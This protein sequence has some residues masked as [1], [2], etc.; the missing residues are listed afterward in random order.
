MKKLFLL[1]FLSA[2]SILVFSQNEDSTWFLNNYTKLEQYIPMRDGIKLFTS[3]Y[4]PKDQATKHPFLMTR[5][6]YSCA[7]YGADKFIQIWYSYKMK[8][9]RENFIFV[10]QD[11]RGR[12][13]SEGEFVDVRP[14]N[15]NKK[16]KEIDEASDTYDAIDWLVKNIKN[17]NGKVGVTG[18]SYPGFYSTEAA[19]SGH[20]ALVAVSPQAPVTDWFMGDDFHHK[21]AFFVMDG[22]SFYPFFATP[23]PHPSTSYTLGF[24]FNSDDNYNAYLK[25]G[26]LKN[27]AKLVGD[28]I[29]FWHEMYQHP[30]Y[31]A[32]WQERNARVGLYNVKPAMLWV[33][34]LFDAEDCFGAWN[35]YKA[36]EKQSPQTNSRIVMG[37]W[38]HG[39]WGREGSFMGNVRFGSNTSAYFQDSLEIPFFNYY[40]LGKGNTDQ[41]AEANI[42]FSGENNWKKF[43]VWPPKN[44]Q[45][46]NL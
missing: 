44:V 35:S 29:K 16:G 45:Q 28:S 22:L 2:S 15:K 34:G 12:F 19:L 10:T 11:V 13:M 32:W 41:I 43:A 20:P 8:Y 40:L 21:G 36:N 42:F 17:N 39:Q 9:A 46:E 38:Y 1:I 25:A 7:P 37:P 27:I 14:F 6:P 31:D 26:S 18:T 24:H 4:I 30:N 3:I 5:T 23:H 33:G